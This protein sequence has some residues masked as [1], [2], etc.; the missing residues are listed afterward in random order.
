MTLSK[1]A[2]W[3]SYDRS[4]YLDTSI[5]DSVEVELEDETELEGDINVC[6]LESGEVLI[7]TA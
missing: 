3:E 6:A 1:K 5:E 2:W 7:S 4:G